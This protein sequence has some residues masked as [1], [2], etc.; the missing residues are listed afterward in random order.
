MA[1]VSVTSGYSPTITKV[2][3]LTPLQVLWWASYVR[4]AG[5][6]FVINVYSEWPYMRTDTAI[7]NAGYNSGNWKMDM[8]MLFLIGVVWRA[9]AYAIMRWYNKP[10]K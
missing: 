5:E 4:W 7:E 1:V 8:G 3:T 10:K 2:E 6:A 9:I